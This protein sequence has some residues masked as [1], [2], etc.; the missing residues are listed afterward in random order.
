[1]FKMIVDSI[2]RWVGCGRPQGRF[3]AEPPAGSRTSGRNLQNKLK[4]IP[5]PECMQGDAARAYKLGRD[6]AALF[7][8]FVIYGIEKCQECGCS[9]IW[10]FTR[11]G[12]FF[13]ALHRRI[14]EAGLGGG[15]LPRANLLEVSRLTTFGPAL[16]NLSIMGMRR[17]WSQYRVQSVNAMLK[18][19]GVAS[20]AL[21]EIVRRHGLD[22][23]EAVT[24]PWL[25]RRVCALFA[26]SD[27]T[28]QV[29]GVLQKNRNDLLA[30]LQ[31]KGFAEEAGV[32]RFVVDIGWRGTIQDNIAHL[33]PGLRV[34][35]LYLGMQS[36]LNEQPENVR[37]YV[38]GPDLN[39]QGYAARRLLEPMLF[40]ETLC[41]SPAGTTTGYARRGE[42]IVALRHKEPSEDAVF[43]SFTQFFQNGVLDAVSTVCEFLD[44]LNLTAKDL[45]FEALH[46][47]DSLVFE[48]NATLAKTYFTLNRNETFGTGDFFRIPGTFPYGLFFFGLFSSVKRTEYYNALQRS[49]WPQGLLAANGLR[50][51]IPLYNYFDLHRQKYKSPEN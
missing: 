36:L 4:Q 26:D 34:H 21:D 16:G 30:Y 35:G 51:L 41:N 43:N 45:R 11:E 40:F 12:E 25:D 48:P 37:K 33:Y 22:P 49:G 23:D 42:T 3:I 8:L 50:G 14:A 18:T 7:V 5:V 29:D 9:A 32:E 28:G 1:M 17:V 31:E 13:H 10:Y 20:I 27:F 6:N 44:T 39:A 15:Q 19:L 46:L 2:V 47:M 38:F 24:D